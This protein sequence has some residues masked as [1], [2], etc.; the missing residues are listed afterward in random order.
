MHEMIPES[1]SLS[2]YSYKRKIPSIAHH[3]HIRT[4]LIRRIMHCLDLFTIRSLIDTEACGM[5]YS[6]N[7]F[8][9]NSYFV[10]DNFYA[11]SNTIV[12]VPSLT[13]CIDLIKI[14]SYWFKHQHHFI[15][16]C[17]FLIYPF[18]ELSQMMA[19]WCTGLSQEYT[20]KWKQA[21][22]LWNWIVSY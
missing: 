15:E 19:I 10:F 6:R 12:N 11:I 5:F 13:K 4:R 1:W 18:T 22:R 8:I 21:S 9:W 16:V 2:Y 14:Y 3:F 7:H 17:E 20:C